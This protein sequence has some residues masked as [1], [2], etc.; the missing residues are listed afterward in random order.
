MLRGNLSD[1]IRHHQGTL[2]VEETVADGH[3]VRH[4]L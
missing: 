3:V 1:D 2:L 4:L